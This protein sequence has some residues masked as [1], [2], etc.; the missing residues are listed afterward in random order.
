MNLQ[1]SLTQAADLITHVGNDV[2]FLLQGQPGIGKSS[3]LAPIAKATKLKPVYLDCTILDVG[4]VQMPRVTDTSVTFV[5]NSLFVSDQPMLI[6]L[7]EIGKA[8][9]SVQNVLLPLIYER[10]VG[11]HRLPE[12]SR[13]FCT[14]NLVTDGVG[15]ALQGHAINRMGVLQ[16]RNPTAEEWIGWATNHGVHPVVTAWVQ[17]YP[18][19]LASY[20]DEGHR[21]NPYIYRPQNGAAPCVTPRSLAAASHVLWQDAHLQEDVLHTALCGIIGTSAAS[22]MAAFL[23]LRGE[24]FGSWDRIMR[25]PASAPMSS[26]PL[27]NILLCHAA[28][29]R[30]AS[31]TDAADP[32]MQ[33]LVRMDRELQYL[34][35]VMAS[36]SADV[37]SALTTNSTTFRDWIIA[38]RFVVAQQ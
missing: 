9:R 17:E 37:M 4:D 33:Y 35:V 1:V 22:D 34:F 36:S 28:Q 32:W 29:A 24:V 7:D 11:A 12:G 13:V 5:P 3:M 6:M 21:S 2:T 15:D 27:A 20:L 31:D 8:P 26:N 30:I 23:S 14:T 18:Q 38:N 19:C 16:V 25:E 10:R